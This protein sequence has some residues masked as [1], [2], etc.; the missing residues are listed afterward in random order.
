M[1]VFALSKWKFIV[2]NQLTFGAENLSHLVIL[3]VDSHYLEAMIGVDFLGHHPSSKANAYHSGTV[4]A[5]FH[6]ML[7]NS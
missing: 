6:K 4:V 5:K 1:R 3:Y 7:A 2:I